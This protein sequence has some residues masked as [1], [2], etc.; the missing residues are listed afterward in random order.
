MKNIIYGKGRLQREIEYVF[1]DMEIAYYIVDKIED[2]T[3]EFTVDKLKRE[4]DFRVII[5]GEDRQKIENKLM[6]IGLLHGKNY[7]YAEELFPLL[8]GEHYID[9]DELPETVVVW[10]TGKL[11]NI[12]TTKYSK[13]K[14]AY[15]IDSNPKLDGTYIEGIEVKHPDR[16]KDWKSYYII[17]AVNICEEI[18]RYL[19]G[20]GLKERK[21]YIRFSQMNG[22]PSEMMRKVCLAEQQAY[23]MCMQMFR[24][25]FIGVGG[26]VHL[27]CPHMIHNFPVGNL[28]EN[29]WEECWNSKLAKIMRLSL[30]N[31]TF[32]FCDKPQCANFSQEIDAEHA[33]ELLSDYQI[34]PLNFPKEMVLAFD[35]SC[36]LQCVSCRKEFKFNTTE[37]ERKILEKTTEN[38]M[39]VAQKV[40]N[41][42]VSGNG[43]PIFSKW[44]RQLWLQEPKLRRKNIELVTNGLLFNETNWKKFEDLYENISVDI[45]VDAA[46][47]E[48]Y[49]RIRIGGNFD[50]LTENL[51]FISSLREQGKIK[52]FTIRFVVQRQNYEEMP[53]FVELGRRLHVD[54]VYFCKIANWNMYSAE[55]FDK[56]S[57]FD[58]DDN[59]KPEL[60]EV[61]QNSIFDCSI[62]D[63]S[64]M[65]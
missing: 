14:I 53:L 64:N 31:R 37:A 15:Y 34:R 17:V 36:N 1:D 58:N 63:F 42:Q 3:T 55:E 40:E 28:V 51:K 25:A 61:L 27:C 2:P 12:L 5:C 13:V 46:T 23:P 57:M 8:N 9:M 44:Y 43:D 52:K 54:K 56:I 18:I 29:T 7:I 19:Q 41:L 38:L 16:I 59:M 50:I 24:F 21:D 33:K 60:A 62:I 39:E 10:G 32:C 49:E 35:S 30:I 26:E 45:S 6:A 11:S 48:T 20:L 4:S 22:A 65:R 47:K